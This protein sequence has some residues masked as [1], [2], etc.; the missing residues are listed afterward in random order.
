MMKLT[1]R[2]GG[3]F[4]CGW[5]PPTGLRVELASAVDGVSVR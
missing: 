2:Y 5:D 1:A 3:M 4:S